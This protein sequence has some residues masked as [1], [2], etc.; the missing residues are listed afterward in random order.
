M[1]AFESPQTCAKAIIESNGPYCV[2]VMSAQAACHHL[3]LALVLKPAQSCPALSRDLH[4]PQD[5]LPSPLHQTPPPQTTLLRYAHLPSAFES[6]HS[7]VLITETIL[8]SSCLSSRN[9]NSKGS[10]PTTQGQTSWVLNGARYAHIPMQTYRGKESIV[11]TGLDN[12]Q[13]I[14]HP[15]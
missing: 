3:Q 13:G 2:E 1:L 8:F 6:P 4:I 7:L 12:E 10:Q 15:V 11:Q 14:V 9:A 5:H